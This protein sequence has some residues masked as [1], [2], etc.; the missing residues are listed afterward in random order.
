MLSDL[1]LR[2]LQ[3]GFIMDEQTSP[4]PRAL[5]L[6]LGGAAHDLN[7]IFSQV[8]M[9]SELFG[10]VELDDELREMLESLKDSIHRGIGISGQLFDQS[11]AS[12]GSRLKI[13]LKQLAS[14]L[15]KRGP[16][17]VPDARITSRY[18]E[19]VSL[20]T[21]DPQ[22]ILGAVLDI[23][24][25]RA[26]EQP[27]GTV[28]VVVEEHEG[29]EQTRYVSIGVSAP[30]S[31]V[32]AGLSSASNGEEPNHPLWV[33]LRETMSLQ[34]GWLESGPG[35]HGPVVRLCVPASEG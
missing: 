6:L 32:D 33:R 15:Q 20:T 21:I 9:L 10:T 3:V 18:P 11:V 24:R 12:E 27:G 30:T 2:V 8:L 35:G 14:A 13:S 23:A 25:L 28:E 29:E 17:L 19:F 31:L 7:N 4:E 5:D 16:D 34:G 26:S 22:A 1:K